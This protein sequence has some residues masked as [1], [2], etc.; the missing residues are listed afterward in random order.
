MSCIVF[1]IGLNISLEPEDFKTQLES[2]N[3]IGSVSVTR[4]G[5]CANY[6]MSVT[7]VTLPGNQEQI[8][9]CKKFCLFYFMNYNDMYLSLH[10]HFYVK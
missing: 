5:D 4:E 1:L 6:N 3:G 7:F 2:L 10:D 9:V 8:Q